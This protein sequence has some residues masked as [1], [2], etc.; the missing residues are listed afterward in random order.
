MLDIY[1]NLNDC[2]PCKNLLSRRRCSCRTVD[3]ISASEICGTRNHHLS[4]MELVLSHNNKHRNSK[5]SFRHIFRSFTVQTNRSVRRRQTSNRT[6]KQRQRYGHC[7]WQF[8]AEIH[9]YFVERQIHGRG[10]NFFSPSSAI[11]VQGIL[12]ADV[13][14]V[15]ESNL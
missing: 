6:A 4:F 12:W 11:R 13:L 15:W 3:H 2:A 8:S 10:I 7:T 14:A 5:Q 1:F 9:N